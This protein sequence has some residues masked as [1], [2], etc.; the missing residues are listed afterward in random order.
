MTNKSEDFHTITYDHYDDILRSVSFSSDVKD[1]KI[2]FGTGPVIDIA[3]KVDA[4][5][6]I[7]LRFQDETENPKRGI[8]L[9][10][11][12]YMY[13][14]LSFRASKDVIVYSDLQQYVD[15]Q[16]R[17]KCLRSGIKF[18]MK[19]SNKEIVTLLAECGFIKVK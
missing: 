8:P 15:P 4:K 3:D 17:I 6:I 18:Q 16:Y 19:K 12:P 2:I 7:Y 14:S 13:V 10:C 11:L 5:Q 1:L 9:F